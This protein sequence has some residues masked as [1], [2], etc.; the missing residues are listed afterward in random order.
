MSKK[1]K[2]I[3]STVTWI[4]VVLIAILAILLAGI[5]VLGFTPL[6]VL[7][8]SMQPEIPTGSVVYVAKVSPE[9]IKEGDVISY[10]LDNET[11]STHRVVQILKTEPYDNNPSGIKYVVKGDANEKNDE[12]PVMHSN[13]IGKVSFH[14]PALGYVSEFI[15][16]PPG[17]YIAISAG[18]VLLVLIFFPEVFP[19]KK[20][21][22][23][24]PKH[25]TAAEGDSPSNSDTQ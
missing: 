5:R 25:E 3:W 4:P 7:S 21:N 14:I 20:E 24:D 6:T 11:V 2:R 18:L 17:T 16:N 19:E 1:A 9:N 22:K 15:K 8:G 23:G 12:R 13:V 10:M